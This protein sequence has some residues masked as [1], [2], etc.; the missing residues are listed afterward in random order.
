MVKPQCIQSRIMG[1][2]GGVR[3]PARYLAAALREQYGK[4][5]AKVAPE[6]PLVKDLQDR[7][8]ILKKVQK[9]AAARSPIQRDADKR[10]FATSIL[11]SDL[12]NDFEN[13]GWTS[14][15]NAC[16]IFTFSESLFPDE[17]TEK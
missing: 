2:A 13:H 12:R 15:L 8:A 16:A 10:S 17:F 11:R 1:G 3:D 9:L 7:A 14:A 6:P 4:D 5:E